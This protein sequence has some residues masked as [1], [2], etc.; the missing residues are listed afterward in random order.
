MN[1]QNQNQTHADILLCCWKKYEI[2]WKKSHS[3]IQI[4]CAGAAGK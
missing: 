1:F 3:F 4:I 2:M